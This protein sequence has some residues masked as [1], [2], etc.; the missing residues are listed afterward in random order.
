MKAQPTDADDA[1]TRALLREEQDLDA[2]SVLRAET[3]EP[4]SVS[5]ER[6]C[7]R[8][9]AVRAKQASPVSNSRSPLFRL[10]TTVQSSLLQIL[11][12]KT[13]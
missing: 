10:S 4:R 12:G 11:E 5:L 13:K 1:T 9:F 3:T 7:Q 2:S 8:M 6:P